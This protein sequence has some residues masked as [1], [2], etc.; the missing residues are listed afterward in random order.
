MMPQAAGQL[1][2][3]CN[4]CGV[5]KKVPTPLPTA[6]MRYKEHRY[7]SKWLM[8]VAPSH[9]AQRYILIALFQC[10]RRGSLERK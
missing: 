1:P 4:L 3:A 2:A 8:F 5:L 7:G 6:A 9:S 10:F